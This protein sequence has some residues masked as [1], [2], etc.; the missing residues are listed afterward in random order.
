MKKMR[1]LR[2]LAFA[3]LAA[4]AFAAAQS[5][6]V[7]K[8]ASCGCC[9]K[10]I[11]HLRREGFQA[12]ASD[13]PRMNEVKA[14]FGVPMEMRSCHTAVVGGYVIEGHVPAADIRRLLA[15][16]PKVAG[17]AAPGMPAGSPGMDVPGAPPYT[18]YAFSRTGTPKAYA[19]H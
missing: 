8:D 17:L 13:T 7:Y 6:V 12:H 5:V 3:A 19:T 1:M 14:R 11:E 18:V 4:P 16:K 2:T 10:W 15:E 9:A